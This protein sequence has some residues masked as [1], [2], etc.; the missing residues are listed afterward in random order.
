EGTKV[1]I[2]NESVH[3]KHPL[4][5]LRFKNTSGMQLMQGPIT[6]FEGSNYAGDARILDLQPN[7]ERLL[8]YAIDLG[9]EVKVEGDDKPEQI[10]ALKVVKG[11]MEV[12]MKYEQTKKFLIKNRNDQAKT[13]LLELP[14]REGWKLKKPTEPSERS[15]DVYRFQVK[16]EAGGSTQHEVKEEMLDTTH[17]QLYAVDTPTMISYSQQGEADAE[18]KAFLK[19]AIELRQKLADVQRQ[20]SETTR[21]MQTNTQDQDRLRKNLERLPAN[22]AIYQETLHKFE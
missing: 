22:S 21:Q 14:I 19:R 2:F 3:A 12:T 4:L 7:E 5:G 11:V 16:L 15:R 1:S 20:L 6:V 10:T 17:V 18:T 8:S 9:T 13:L